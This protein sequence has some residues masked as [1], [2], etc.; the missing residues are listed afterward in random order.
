MSDGIRGTAKADPGFE[1]FGAEFNPNAWD[2]SGRAGG[3][4]E[5][6]SA[7][8]VR[9]VKALQAQHVRIFVPT[10]VAWDL[11]K[12]A[13]PKKRA[14]AQAK[15]DSFYRTVKLAHDSGASINLTWPGGVV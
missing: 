6:N 8:L 9:D 15:I 4:T 12:V 14:E 2:F 5:S 1:G 3:I 13:T 10:E 7:K 11:S